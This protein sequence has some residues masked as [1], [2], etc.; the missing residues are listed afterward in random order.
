MR[1]TEKFIEQW[2]NSRVPLL[3]L[4]C[5][6]SCKDTLDIEWTYCFSEI[7]NVLNTNEL[8]TEVLLPFTIK[9]ECSTT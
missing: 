1:P 8:L 6:D 3:L 7:Q 5:C 2:L 4:N 9:K